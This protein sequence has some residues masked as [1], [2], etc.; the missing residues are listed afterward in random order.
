MH[1]IFFTRKK[2][3]YIAKFF[4]LMLI[5]IS[6]S[7]KPK[8]TNELIVGKW[9]Y[10]KVDYDKLKY[11]IED[12]NDLRLINMFIENLKESTAEYFK[13]LTYVKAVPKFK[14]KENGEYKLINDGKFIVCTHKSN[15]QDELKENRSEIV[16]LTSDSLLIKA[17]EGIIIHYSRVNQ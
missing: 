2:N 16:K 5:F 3:T 9:K 11:Q 6:V 10:V 17:D 4:L 12:E 14:I 13:D 8:T 15:R 1:S 7:C